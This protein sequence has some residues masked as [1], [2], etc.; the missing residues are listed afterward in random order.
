MLISEI[1]TPNPVTITSEATLKEAAD[2]MIKKDVGGLPVVDEDGS[3]KGI[4]TESDFL[5]KESRIPFTS[6]RMPSLFGK[7][8]DDTKIEEIYDAATVLKVKDVMTADLTTISSEKHV[9][10]AIRLMI[11][12]RVNRL[13][14]V[15]DSGK[16]IGIV[17]RRD[18]MNAFV[19]FTDK[20]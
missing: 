5:A 11:T 10:D 19:R 18:V 17:A 8:M 1:M 15:D 2:R 3:L 6:L 9:R 12:H 20:G 16:L 7:W 4:I 14:V 13:P